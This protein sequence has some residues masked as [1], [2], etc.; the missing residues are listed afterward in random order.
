MY[1]LVEALENLACQT[2]VRLHRRARVRKILHRNGRLRGLELQSGEELPCELAVSN[3]DLPT[4]LTELLG[5]A[6]PQMT[7]SPSVVTFY[8]VVRERPR[9]L[10]HHT[11]FL[12]RDYRATFQNLIQGRQIPDDPAFYV[13]CPPRES[14]PQ[15]GEQRAG[16]F[17]LVPV[18][19]LSR[20]QGIAWDEETQ[21]LKQSVLGRLKSSGIGLEADGIQAERVFTP[22][23]WKSRFG[24]YQGSAFG[25]AHTLGQVGPFRPKNYS[26]RVRGLYFAGASTTPG[27]GVPMV[28]ISGRLA[29]ER[30][31]AHAR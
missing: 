7:M 9:G 1:K 22:V 13:A 8:W 15:S 17:V 11:I 28:V 31:Q 16:V 23:E 3:V 2:G 5:E 24:L 14:E 18:P 19:L 12:P 21:R 4:T 29:A 6:R 30:I 27:T 10:G 25:A 20:L 26:Q